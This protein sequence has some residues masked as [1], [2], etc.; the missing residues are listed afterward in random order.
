MHSRGESWELEEIGK[1]NSVNTVEQVMET[2][3]LELTCP[4]RVP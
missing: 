4:A 3:T 1:E 2:S